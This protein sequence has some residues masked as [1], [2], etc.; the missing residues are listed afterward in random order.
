MAPARKLENYTYDD[1]L[2]I[3]RTT[4]ENER[5]EL[6]FGEI[7]MMAGANAVHQ[8]VVGNIFFLLRTEDTTRSCKP[9]IAPF[10]LKLECGDQMNVVQPDVLL[11]CGDNTLPCALFEVLSPSTAYRDK[12]VKKELYEKC[13][14]REYFIVNINERIVDHYLLKNGCYWYVRGF[15]EKDKMEI[16]CLGITVNV[17]EIFEGIDEEEKYHST[18]KDNQA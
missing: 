4:K 5:I 18:N 1:Y 14:I 15:G 11:Y 17:G 2:E 12:G 9:R 16:H 13:R 7:Y 10:D 8:D 3:D 6:I